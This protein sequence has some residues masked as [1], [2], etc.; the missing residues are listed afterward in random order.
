[1]Q[2]LDFNF[3]TE[4]KAVQEVCTKYFELTEQFKFVFSVNEL[5]NELAMSSTQLRQLV[6]V[7]SEIRCNS[8]QCPSCNKGHLVTGRVQLLKLLQRNEKVFICHECQLIEQREEEIRIRIKKERRRKLIIDTYN[9][10]MSQELTID[11]LSF[12]EALYLYVL[13]QLVGS[14]NFTQI[15]P[16]NFAMT[17][18]SPTSKY[19]KEIILGLYN[20]EKLIFHEDNL[21]MHYRSNVFLQNDAGYRDVYWNI[22]SGGKE[23]FYDLY[24]QLNDLFSSDKWLRYDKDE[25]KAV[26]DKVCLY[27][28]YYQLRIVMRK[29]NFYLDET[30]QKMDEC[31]TYALNK[32]PLQRVYYLIYKCVNDAA[33]SMQLSHSKVKAINS[34]PGKIQRI[35]DRAVNGNWSITAYR[36]IPESELSILSSTI[37]EKL[38]R[39]GLV[40]FDMRFEDL[41]WFRLG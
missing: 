33:A 32:F 19:D 16:L 10:K 28:A 21:L 26:W 7:N 8:I 20:A 17:N 3:S 24:T 12:S 1:M 37:V 18:L 41:I 38:F 6:K 40:C 4:D 14:D 13:I 9:E 31:L 22:P 15:E 27:E 11:Q 39:R 2:L 36:R 23:S 29:F 5:A 34:I 35:T 30:N 25:I